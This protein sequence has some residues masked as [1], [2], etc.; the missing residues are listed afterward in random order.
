[1]IHG[2]MSSGGEGTD[3][4]AT[5]KQKPACKVHPGQWEPVRSNR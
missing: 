3:G 2:V 4:I 5:R 1:M